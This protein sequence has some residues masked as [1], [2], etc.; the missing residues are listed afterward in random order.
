MRIEMSLDRDS[1]LLGDQVEMTLRITSVPAVNFA[2]PVIG[3]TLMPSIEVLR[4]SP[5]DTLYGK[6]PAD[7]L[8]IVER[9]YTLT[10]F[11]AG[12]IYTLPQ[13]QFVAG[14]DTFASNLVLLK[15]LF[16]AMDTT[17]RV[18]DIKPPIEYPITFAEAL[19]YVGGGLLLLGLVAFLIYCLDRRR[20]H[21]PL[22]FKPKPKD[23]AHITA[24]R[25]LQKLKGEQLWQAGR[26]KDFHTRISE[27]LRTYIEDRFAVQAMEQTSDE[28]LL[29]MNTQGLCGGGDLEVLRGVFYLSDLVKFA[30]YSA[31]ADENETAFAQA[32]L[33][34]EHTKAAETV[35]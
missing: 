10:C 26:I 8:S 24:L 23:P 12:V 13:F 22:F 9:R 31:A 30:K 25:A 35:S 20:R 2:F 4:Q 18:N 5:L 3:D 14:G 6:K 34:V 21:Q 1:M 7:T 32:A 28:I 17:W 16:P 11:D 27:I 19:P 33:F 15:V 29:A